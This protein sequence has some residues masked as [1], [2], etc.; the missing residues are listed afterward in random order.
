M[1]LGLGPSALLRA[2]AGQY[3]SLVAEARWRWLPVA[4][5]EQTWSLSAGVRLH[6]GKDLSLALEGRR[7][8]SDDSVS[9]AV[10]GYF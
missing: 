3:A 10:L 4:H 8:P 1:R 9:A 5:P 7:T 2:R 6:A